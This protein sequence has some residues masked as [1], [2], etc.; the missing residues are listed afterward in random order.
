MAPDP[1]PSVP[2]PPRRTETEQER[3]Y[4][5][6][7]S[8]HYMRFIHMAAFAAK[9]EA[10]SWVPGL[11]YCGVCRFT[12]QLVTLY[13]RSGTTGAGNHEPEACLNGCGPMVPVTWEQRAQELQ[14]MY[15]D[16][17]RRIQELEKRHGT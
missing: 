4:T 2:R 17:S 3:S 9:L 12:L 13:V 8:N 5:K 7:G 1:L 6:Y 14:E 10:E 11:M 15:E 16:I